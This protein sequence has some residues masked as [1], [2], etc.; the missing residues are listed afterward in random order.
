MS[1]NDRPIRKSSLRIAEDPIDL[2]LSEVASS[3]TSSFTSGS[4]RS[5]AI[6]MSDRQLVAHDDENMFLYG[7]TVDNGDDGEYCNGHHDNGDD[8]SNMSPDHNISNE[9]S[10]IDI[11]AKVDDYTIESEHMVTHEE[12]SWSKTLAGVAGNVLEWYDFAIFGYFSD[13]LGDVFF[14]PHQDGHAAIVESFAVFGGAFFVRPIGGVMMVSLYIMYMQII[15]IYIYIM[16]IA[17]HEPLTLPSYLP[18]F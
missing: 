18:F 4:N 2:E 6:E 16:Y 10:V 13:V 14:P 11:L 3:Y 1:N 5:I 12:D 7:S 9:E 15:Y 17:N 8:R